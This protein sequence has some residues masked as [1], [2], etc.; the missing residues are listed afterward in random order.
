MA[1]IE[2]DVTV[3]AAGAAVPGVDAE[4][5]DGSGWRTRVRLQVAPDG[6]FG[7]FASRSHHVVE[8]DDL[9]LATERVAESTPFGQRFAGA[10]SID[11]IA[12]TGGSAHVL[13]NDAPVKRGR[14]TIRPRLRPM[15]V[16]EHVGDREFQLDARGFWQVHRLAAATLTEAVQS[17]IDEALFDPRAANLDLYGG[18]GLLSAAVGDRFGSTVRIT[19]V[20]GDE[21]A[22]DHAAENLA[23]WIGANAVTSRV[24]RFVTG[25]AAEASPA[26]RS[27]FR[28]A[29]VILDPPRS[30]A[31]RAVVDAIAELSP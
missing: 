19:S 4:T 20:E 3:E 12:T 5:A 26:E 23:E 11:V 14:R 1:K 8:V 7:P 25:L 21:T 15:P 28:A 6:A 16:R 10:E 17:A 13:V 30:G 27:R 31:G 2:R 9:P 24:E 18:V 29:T 22:T